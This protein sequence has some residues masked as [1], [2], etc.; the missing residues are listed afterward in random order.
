MP[1]IVWHALGSKADVQHEFEAIR[2]LFRRLKAREQQE[3]I[4]FWETA[5]KNPRKHTPISLHRSR[6]EVLLGV[7]ESIFGMSDLRLQG[8]L[9]LLA[10]YAAKAG[11]AEIAERYRKRAIGLR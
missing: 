5:A 2:G 7:E 3:L 8:V 11:E 10:D 9:K 1:E 4:D 6:L